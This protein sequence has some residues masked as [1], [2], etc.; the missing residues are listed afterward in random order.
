[1]G[2]D[3][4]EVRVVG[5][6][7]TAIVDALNAL[8]HRWTYV[9]TTGGIRA[10]HG[11]ITPDCVGKRLRVP[12][13]GDPPRLAIPHEW[14]KT[15]RRGMSNARLSM[16]RIPEGADL[17]LKQGVRGAWLLDRQCDRDGWRA[18]DHAGDAR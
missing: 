11:N 7:E 10:S 12:I 4:K 5:A 3:L 15:T 14:A 16:T 8:R 18:L 13:D 2:I 6:E 1:V 17:I 9:F